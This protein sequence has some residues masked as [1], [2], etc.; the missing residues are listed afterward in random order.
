MIMSN[1]NITSLLTIP[2][3]SYPYHLIHSFFVIFRNEYEYHKI[4]NA[5]LKINDWNN[6]YLKYY[7]LYIILFSIDDGRSLDFEKYET[8]YRNLFGESNLEESLAKI[9]EILLLHDSKIIIAKLIKLIIST[10]SDEGFF[11][12]L[13]L[14]KYINK[15]YSSL[16]IFPCD[17]LIGVKHIES[18]YVF[19]HYIN[20][21]VL[22]KYGSP[23][24][25]DLLSQIEALY[26]SNK[27]SLMEKYGIKRIYLFGSVVLNEYHRES[28]IDMVVEL[29][30]LDV[31]FVEITKEISSLNMKAFN[32]KSDIYEYNDFVKRNKHIDLYLLWQRK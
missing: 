22:G 18:D 23:F 30:S 14:S 3:I 25:E 29:I 17:L 7:V 19:G 10:Q 9:K 13:V 24:K 20:G 28:D 15:I 21:V 4:K 16:V 6:K 5:V 12:F 27:E 26:S 32:R 11:I 2:S 31:D 1:D 8:F